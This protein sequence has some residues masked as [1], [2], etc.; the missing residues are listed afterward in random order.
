MRVLLDTH[1]L[2]WWLAGSDRLTAVARQAIDD[3]ANDVLV[4]AASAWEIA[5]KYRLGRLPGAA[6]VAEDVTGCLLDQGFQP[7]AITVADGERAGRLPG[8]VRDPFDRMLIAQAL[9]LDAVLISVEEP[10][11]RYGV[12]RL[13]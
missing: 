12:R 8:P 1:A 4:S 9:R 10:F 6:V 3:G 7:L 5:T 11:D 2:L 13:W